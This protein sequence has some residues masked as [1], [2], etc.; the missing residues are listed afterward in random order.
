MCSSD[1][2]LGGQCFDKKKSKSNA[3]NLAV[4]TELFNLYSDHH[5]QNFFFRIQ[6]QTASKM[7]YPHYICYSIEKLESYMLRFYKLDFIKEN[8]H[9]RQFLVS[10]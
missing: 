3:G 1:L 2:S 5:F 8:C 7:P 9:N 6:E 10:E 4:Q